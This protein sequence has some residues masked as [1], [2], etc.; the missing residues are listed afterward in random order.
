MLVNPDFSETQ[1]PIEPGEYKVRI[2]G[3]EQKTS[4]NDQPYLR[5]ELTTFASANPK[6]DGRKMW[7]TTMLAGRGAGMLKAFYKAAT[8]E[9]LESNFDT[10]QLV[11]RELSVIV[12]LDDRGYTN[13]KAVKPIQ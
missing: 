7:H 4:R 1:D 3:C 5:W 12:D 2:T 10:E 8:T 11:G 6:N 9:D 13:V